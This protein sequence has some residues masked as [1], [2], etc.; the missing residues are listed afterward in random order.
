MK[1]II[2]GAMPAKAVRG[3]QIK[4]YPYKQ[5]SASAKKLAEVVGGKV[6]K[7]EGS[8]YVPR[9]GDVVVNWGAGRVPD[10]GG[11][12]VL[13]PNVTTAGCKLASFLALEEAGVRVPPFAYSEVNVGFA[14]KAAADFQF[15]VVC[16]TK[17]RGHSGDGIVI[18]NNADEL[19]DAPLYTQYVKKQDEYRVHVFQD[20]IIFIQRKARKLDN[21][22]PNWQVRNLAGGFAFVAVDILE[23]PEDVTQQALDAIAALELDF[24]G[25][26]VMW[27]AKEAKAYVLE[28]NTACGLEDRTAAFYREAILREAGLA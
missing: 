16:R 19:V 24:G 7:V 13:N 15:P 17:L 6:L 22:N 3:P 5:G 23:V 14:K 9:V 10:F 12:T 27:N 28:V 26:D 1:K 21:E 20:T 2:K 8:K 18:A 25:V 11:A 4:V